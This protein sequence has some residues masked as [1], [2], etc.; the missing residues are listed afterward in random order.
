MPEELSPILFGAM[1][2]RLGKEK[3]QNVKILLD[4]GSSGTLIDAKL[5]KHLR[6]K[7]ESGTKWNTANGSFT[8]KGKVKVDFSLPE[9]YEERTIR[10]VMHPTNNL[11]YDI[12]IGRDLLRELG[13]TSD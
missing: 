4:S 7:K 2:R 6:I 10:W 8:T 13:I 11:G 5:T 3:L 1:N 12:I 9:M